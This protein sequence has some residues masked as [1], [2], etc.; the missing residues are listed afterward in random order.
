MLVNSILSWNWKVIVRKTW[1][2]FHTDLSLNKHDYFK[3]LEEYIV[4]NVYTAYWV[5]CIS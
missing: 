2:A 1:S 4:Y 3:E 5:Y